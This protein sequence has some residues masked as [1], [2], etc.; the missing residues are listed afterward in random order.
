MKVDKGDLVFGCVYMPPSLNFN[1][2]CDSFESDMF[3][4][5]G[6]FKWLTL[7]GV[8]QI[9]DQRTQGVHKIQINPNK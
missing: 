7:F 9:I 1:Q 3:L 8:T 4:K 6:S 5:N 2:F